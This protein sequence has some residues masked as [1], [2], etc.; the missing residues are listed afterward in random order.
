VKN[1]IL[2]LLTVVSVFMLSISIYSYSQSKTTYLLIKD[3]KIRG[4]YL[5][6]MNNWKMSVYGSIALCILIIIYIFLNRKK[7]FRKR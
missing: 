2:G 1:F 7:K 3:L 4:I 6:S 5:E